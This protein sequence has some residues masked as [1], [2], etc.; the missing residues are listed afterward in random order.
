LVDLSAEDV[1]IEINGDLEKIKKE[2]PLYTYVE[3]QKYLFDKYREAGEAILDRESEI[4]QKMDVF[5]RL[6]G[7]L[8]VLFEIDQNEK[9][10][11]LLESMESYLKHIFE[12]NNF[13]VSY[14]KL[15]KAYR[16]FVAL[17]DIIL[18]SRNRDILEKEPLCSICLQEPVLYAIV[19]CG[20][21][22]C[23]TC[24]RR[25]AGNCYIC[26]GSIKEKVKLFF[27]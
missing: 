24:S 20:H 9:Y 25:Q 1:L 4:H 15:L 17:R 18:M 11:P 16:Y 27:G 12:K 26:R 2:T 6:Q 7:K 22:F 10:E 5:D 8:A 13:D 3:Q 21:T 23:Q 14:I 19:P